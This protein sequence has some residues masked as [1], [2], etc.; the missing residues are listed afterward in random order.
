MKRAI[1]TYEIVLYDELLHP[2][3]SIC[4]T[5]R[6]EKIIDYRLMGKYGYIATMADE[7]KIYA[8]GFENPRQPKIEEIVLARM[9][10]RTLIPVDS[11]KAIG[12]AYNIQ[13]DL[14]GG[15]LEDGIMLSLFNVK[16][17]QK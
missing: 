9:L 3:T 12:I 15:T 1:R 14:Y 8:V 10:P 4:E 6:G 13:K 16:N 11:E 7:T 5:A 2:L 17:P